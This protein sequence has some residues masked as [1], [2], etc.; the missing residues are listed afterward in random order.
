MKK[1]VKFTTVLTSFAMGM[2]GCVWMRVGKTTQNPNDIDLFDP[3]VVRQ[4]IREPVIIPRLVLWI[5]VKAGDLFVVP[6]GQKIVSL[7]NEINLHLLGEVDCTGLTF[8][9]LTEKL[10]EAY[11][12]HYNEPIVTRIDW[13]GISIDYWGMVGIY[14]EVAREGRLNIPFPH[15][16]SLSLT[17]ALEQAGGF[18]PQADRSRIHVTRIATPRDLPQLTETVRQGK[19]FDY[20]KIVSGQTPDPPLIK[21]DAVRV[22]AKQKQ[23]N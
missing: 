10:N 20:E 12:K 3:E 7:R 15:V 4:L 19:V 5:E 13:Y 9:Q 6:G 18:T 21:D 1:H 14:G 17:N 22:W 8:R 16:Y 11:K 23:D 2:A